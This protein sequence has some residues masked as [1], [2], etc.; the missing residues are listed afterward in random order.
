MKKGFTLVELL[1]V[2]MVL[3][4][5]IMIVVTN[6]NILNYKRIYNSYQKKA[7]EDVLNATN[8][9]RYQFPDLRSFAD[10]TSRFNVVGNNPAGN[11]LV[12]GCG[13]GAVVNTCIRGFFQTAIRGGTVCDSADNNPNNRCKEGRVFHTCAATNIANLENGVYDNNACGNNNFL[14]FN[15]GIAMGAPGAINVSVNNN[16]TIGLR[17]KN[18]EVIM[19]ESVSGNCD[20]SNIP[21]FIVFVDMN[22]SKS[23]N[24]YGQDRYRFF[25]YRNNVVH[26]DSN[27][28]AYVN[29]KSLTDAER[30]ILRSMRQANLNCTGPGANADCQAFTR[31]F[32]GHA[33]SAKSQ[34]T[35]CI[36]ELNQVAP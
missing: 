10:I 24:I 7:T 33:Y 15:N 16:P 12:P 4:A 3:G 2:M 21:C 13:A 11:P 28:V 35:S 19:F 20:D 8:L 30:T 14:T 34:V 31:C 5:I 32:K 22:G 26:D 36:A 29:D 1:L 18:G 6:Q 27:D 25:V 9:I 17:M 23:P